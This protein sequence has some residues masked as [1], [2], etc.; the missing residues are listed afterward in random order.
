MQMRDDAWRFLN[1]T[2]HIPALYAAQTGLRVIDQVGVQ[3]IREK[4]IHQTTRLLDLADEYG[5]KTTTPKNPEQRGG[6]V[7]VDVPH[8]YETMK[9]LIRREFLVDYRPKAGI[10]LSPHFYNSDEELELTIKEIRKI[11]EGA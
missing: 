5:F 11:Q 10:R 8:G 1:G 6:T 4:S 9:E 3:V 2:P 7:A